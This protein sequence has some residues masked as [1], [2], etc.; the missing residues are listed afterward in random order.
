[1]QLSL[2]PSRMNMDAYDKSQ[3]RFNSIQIV[4][5]IKGWYEAS[6]SEDQGEEMDAL[7]PWDS[8]SKLAGFRRNVDDTGE[9]QITSVG[10]E[11]MNYTT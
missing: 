3:V 9:S 7:F 1:M 2:S 8:T 10:E 4:C 5:H 6:C 11:T